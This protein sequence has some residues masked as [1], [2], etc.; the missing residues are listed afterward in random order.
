MAITTL[1]GF[2]M[3]L[4]AHTDCE[5]HVGTSSEIDRSESYFRSVEW[6]PDG[7]CLITNSADNCIR[8]FIVPPD[9]LDERDRPL[10]LEPYSFIKSTEPAD[11][12]VCFPGYN[13]ED[14]QTAL[15]LSAINEHPIRL[16]S[17]LTG[18]LIASY[19]LVN[20]N[21]EAFIKPQSM[22]FAVDGSHFVAGSEQRISTF[23]VSRPGSDPVSSVRTGPK[24]SRTPWSNPSLSLRGSISALAVDGQYN[25]LAAGTLSRQVGLYDSAGRG[26]CIS[27]FS[28]IGTDADKA[29][30]GNGITQLAW[31]TC[32]RYLYVTERKSDGAMVYDIRSSGQLLS[33]IK[34]R[35]AMTNQRTKVELCSNVDSGRIDIWA[36]G[37]DGKLRCWTDAHL[38]QGELEPSQTVHVHDGMCILLLLS[39]H[40]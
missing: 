11:A 39:C 36:G 6:S 21:T 20:A 27:V 7:T 19:P 32:G 17:A 18:S 29:I 1:L 37:K 13:L 22:I 5:Q 15:V 25:V 10:R 24:K 31:S 14:G 26:E 23:D 8:T 30:S 33:W 3:K 35:A 4:V 40:Y 16:S 2:V 12:V 28:V 9:L 34:G 38:Q